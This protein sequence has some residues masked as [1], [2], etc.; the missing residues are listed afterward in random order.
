MT[1]ETILSKLI[2]KF[3]RHMQYAMTKDNK[4]INKEC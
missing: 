2:L 1:T 4:I 3:Y